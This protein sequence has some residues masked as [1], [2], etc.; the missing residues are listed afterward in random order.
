[1]IREGAAEKQNRRVLSQASALDLLRCFCLLVVESISSFLFGGE[2]GIRTHGTVAGT[3]DFESGTFDHSA[4]SPVNFGRFTAWCSED[5]D[6]SRTI[7]RVE[8]FFEKYSKN[9]SPRHCISRR[10]D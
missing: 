1:M 5:S 4:T 7:F 9:L 8:L 3:P 10:T 6:Y 2:G